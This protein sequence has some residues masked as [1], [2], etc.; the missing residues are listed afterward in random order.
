MPSAREQVGTGSSNQ[1]NSV[2]ERCVTHR[3]L[4]LPPPPPPTVLAVMRVIL[5]GQEGRGQRGHSQP[6]GWR[7]EG[8]GLLSGLRL[9]RRGL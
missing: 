4:Q 9:G 3:L 1:R 7:G 8:T 2:T 6:Q 5:W